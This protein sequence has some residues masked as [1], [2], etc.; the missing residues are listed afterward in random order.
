MRALL[1]HLMPQSCLLCGAHS[2]ANP[3]CPPCTA[4]LPALPE[5]RCTICA[6]PTPTG[7]I[8][9]DCLKTPPAFDASLAAWEYRWPIDRLVP[10][11]KY[12]EQLTLGAALAQGLAHA[13]AGADRPDILLP[14]PLHPKRQRERGFNQSLELAKYLAKTLNLP[15]ADQMVQRVKLTP[16]QASLPLEARH[17]AIKGAFEVAGDVKDR[18]IALVDDVMT[19]GASLNE[20]AKTLKRAGAARVDCWVAARAL[21]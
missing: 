8:C 19:S 3:L 12:G 14:M 11:F 2:Q 13:I 15:L 6:I 20:L 5:R 7:A 18:H 1:D 4:E 17:K 21:R 9:G 16:P 10:A